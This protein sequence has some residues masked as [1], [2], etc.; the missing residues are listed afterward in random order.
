M[1]NKCVGNNKNVCCCCC[2]SCFVFFFSVGCSRTFE[3]VDGDI[4]IVLE[5]VDNAVV[6]V[7]CIHLIKTKFV[8]TIIQNLIHPHFVESKLV[9]QFAIPSE[10]SK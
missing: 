1:A 7:G 10:R 6:V 4:D 3:S 5:N 2:C 9:N 8:V